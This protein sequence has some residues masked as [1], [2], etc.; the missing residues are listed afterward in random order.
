MP[1]RVYEHAR[2]R[3][4]SR[5]LVDQC[6]ATRMIRCKHS[7]LIEAKGDVQV[8]MTAKAVAFT[9]KWVDRCV[10]SVR[11]RIRTWSRISANH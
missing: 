8:A 9:A 3:N 4:M 2:C 10:N 6:R 11:P 5:M 1:E 7:K